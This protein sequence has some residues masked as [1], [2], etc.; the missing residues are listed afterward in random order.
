MIADDHQG[1]DLLAL[2]TMLAEL[3]RD[4]EDAVEDRALDVLVDA[5]LVGGVK[6]VESSLV[7]NFG[8]EVAPPIV[9]QAAS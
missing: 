2:A 6:R 4:R 5:G 7:V 9:K 3:Q 8:L 1:A